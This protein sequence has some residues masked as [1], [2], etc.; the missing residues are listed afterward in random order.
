L[1]WTSALPRRIHAPS[2]AAGGPANTAKTT[3]QPTERIVVTPSSTPSGSDQAHS[4]R[5]RKPSPTPN[6]VTPA[7]NDAVAMPKASSNHTNSRHVI[8]SVSTLR[9]RL[10]IVSPRQRRRDSGTGT[11]ASVPRRRSPLAH[12]C[13]IHT[14]S[15]SLG[16]P[17]SVMISAIDTTGPTKKN[18]S[19]KIPEARPSET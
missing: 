6:A 14:S 10:T 16:I 3:I 19:A 5:V 2:T 17:I 4:G 1:A 9:T 11:P 12:S 15:S 13:M 7:T 8:G 18:V